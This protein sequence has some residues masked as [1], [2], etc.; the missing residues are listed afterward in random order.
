[1]RF[2]LTHLLFSDENGTP[3]VQEAVPDMHDY[4]GALKHTWQGAYPVKTHLY[5]ENLPPRMHTRAAIHIRRN[6]LDVVDSAIAYLSPETD[7]QRTELINTFS[8]VGSIDPWY[9][10]LGYGTWM[11]NL[12]SWLKNKHDFPVLSLK[13]EDMLEDT[14]MSVRKVAEF[15][16]VDVD[17]KRVDEIV[18]ATS[19]KKM[20]SQEEKEQNSKEIG[21]FMDEQRFNKPDFR[22]MRSGKSGS[23]KDNLSEYEIE[24]LTEGFRSTM[25]AYGYL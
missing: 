24:Q 4:Y 18:E 16:S 23:Y 3:N 14:H 21:V 12:E 15:M 20:R 17:D 13:Y 1:M 8:H 10:V 7:K 11:G 5:H 6:P 25:K 9:K 22:F 2:I 19:F